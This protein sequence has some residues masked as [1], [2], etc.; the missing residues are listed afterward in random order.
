MKRGCMRYNKDF[1]AINNVLHNLLARYRLQELTKNSDLLQQWQELA[2][3]GLSDFFKPR[4]LRKGVLYL[5]VPARADK[6]EVTVKKKELSRRVHDRIGGS[7]IKDI[8]FS[9]GK[10]G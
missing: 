10:N 5:E 1:V 6:K 7:F 2:G 3:P 4:Y 8:K 9:R